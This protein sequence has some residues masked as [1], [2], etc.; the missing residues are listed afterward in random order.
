MSFDT[1]K[2]EWTRELR[3]KSPIYAAYDENR[4]ICE[5]KKKIEDNDT[6]TDSG[7]QSID[8][9]T[10]R[11]RA[12][13]DHLFDQD[14]LLTR[15]DSG[16]SSENLEI[17]PPYLTSR[18]DQQV[19]RDALATKNKTLSRTED[20]KQVNL[21]GVPA[22]H[23]YNYSKQHNLHKTISQDIR[24]SSSTKYA[25]DVANNS[26]RRGK[27][28]EGRKYST[29]IKTDELRKSKS[30]DD[31]KAIADYEKVNEGKC[32]RREG[33]C[34]H[35][36]SSL[37]STYGSKEHN[38]ENMK[39][40]KNNNCDD[41]RSE[42]ET[43]NRS[44]RTVRNEKS[45]QNGRQKSQNLILRD[46]LWKSYEETV[47]KVTEIVDQLLYKDLM[48][49]H[50]TEE[51]L[52]FSNNNF[53]VEDEMLDLEEK[54]L[55]GQIFNSVSLLQTLE[56]IG[57]QQVVE[58]KITMGESRR[59]DVEI[60]ERRLKL[61]HMERSFRNMKFRHAPKQL[62]RYCSVESLLSDT[63][64]NEIEKKKSCEVIWDETEEFKE[65]ISLV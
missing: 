57:E 60:K 65:E 21:N 28:T 15:Q 52:N 56:T 6:D 45:M 9:D 13:Y 22:F 25:E 49:A 41:R 11:D 59:I 18:K 42:L 29:K 36:G 19:F 34:K 47:G 27:W 8:G 53:T 37:S 55:E 16:V 62:K 40:D 2:E 3:N 64:H 12:F 58:S 43:V 4:N 48:C 20:A 35:S 30:I 24:K 39:A 1:S 26:N 33:D 10:P 5:I 17:S 7:L 32:K 23:E 50:L 54:F 51:I 38:Y 31:A 61:H 14:L 63:D 44:T 46:D